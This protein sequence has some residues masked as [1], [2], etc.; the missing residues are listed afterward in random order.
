MLWHMK[1]TAAPCSSPVT[2]EEPAIQKSLS[3]L[4]LRSAKGR[5]GIC[6]WGGCSVCPNQRHQARGIGRCLCSRRGQKQARSAV[7]LC[8]HVLCAAKSR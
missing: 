4:Q 6:R 3:Q 5:G 1:G 2:T 8:A 7:V